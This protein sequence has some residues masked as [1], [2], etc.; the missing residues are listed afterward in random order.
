MPRASA[1]ADN[2]RRPFDRT[3]VW[4]QVLAAWSW[5]LLVVGA[6]TV[7]LA[8]SVMRLRVVV[9]PVLIAVMVGAVAAPWV[10]RLRQVGIPR[11]GAT[12]IVLLAGGAIVFAT[13]TVAISGIT[14]ELASDSVR[15]SDVRADV[16]GWL[17]ADP[18]NLSS[19]TVDS[20]ETD[21][22]KAIAGGVS[23]FGSNSAL[24]P[25]EILS[26]M[27]LT[28]ALTFF[29]IKDGPEMWSWLMTRVHRSRRS[30]IDEAGRQA[31]VTLG[32]YLRAVTLTGF[33]NGAAIGLAMWV[34]GVPLAIP[35]AIITF[36]AAFLPVVGATVAGVLA[37]VVALVA[38][39]P[40]DAATLLVV[41]LV[42][43]RIEGDV[44]MPLVMRKQV[45]L[46]PVVVLA[47]ITAGGA[48]A[49]IVGAFIAVPLAAMA[50]AVAAVIGKHRQQ[51]TADSQGVATD[52]G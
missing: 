27:F 44:I 36:F 2:E 40:T 8:M 21:A 33:I 35:L 18:L 17:S 49:G 7:V 45:F 23:S 13:L 28:I 30:A 15:W 26:G 3:P 34:V 46:H 9:V 48:L 20:L 47:A 52:V 51:Q 24:L 31:A 50:S 43:Q 39:G 38:S 42:V 11:L 25:L 32:A 19:A 37:A 14:E 1:T 29:F 12:W 16:R 41:T 22:R 5:R 10:N 6:A 4:L